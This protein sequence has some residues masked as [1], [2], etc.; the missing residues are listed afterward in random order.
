MELLCIHSLR[1]KV[2]GVF[3]YVPLIISCDNDTAGLA[4]H[5]LSE[6]SLG[7]I[8]YIGSQSINSKPKDGQEILNSGY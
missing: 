2:T 8:I 3:L 5:R 6:A 4:K 7:A 1:A